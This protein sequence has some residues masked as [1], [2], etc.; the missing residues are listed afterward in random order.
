M[1]DTVDMSAKRRKQPM[2]S[3][4]QFCP[5]QVINRLAVMQIMK[6]GIHFTLKGRRETY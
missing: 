3:Q 5:S 1:V 6:T 4:I 2:D